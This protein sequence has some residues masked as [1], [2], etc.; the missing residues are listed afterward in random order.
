M[1]EIN[2]YDV[3]VQFSER[4]KQNK[5]TQVIALKNGDFFKNFSDYWL[6]RSKREFSDI[7]TRLTQSTLLNSDEDLCKPLGM[8]YF[9]DWDIKSFL[10]YVMSR[11]KGISLD[12]YMLG[13]MVDAD[14]RLAIYN[15]IQVNLNDIIKKYD[16]MVFP[17]LCAEN[18]IFIEPDSL[19]LQLIDC[20]GFQID[21]YSS[22]MISEMVAED[23][24]AWKNSKYLVKGNSSLYTKELDK[25][26][27]VLLYFFYVFNV[28][29]F[30][31]QSYVNRYDEFISAKL[32]L[33]ELFSL[34]NLQDDNIKHIVWLIFQMDKKKP[35]LYLEEYLLCKLSEEYTLEA[36]RSR[37]GN[38][39]NGSS[40]FCRRLVPKKGK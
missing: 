38:I 1:K 36:F 24:P 29:L 16:N 2:F 39:I 32:S 15:K 21:K 7:E 34:I 33:D 13:S 23:K 30:I 3:E 25:R 4:L 6:A 40:G 37:Y 11:A 26:S 10:G 8:V 14:A 9:E 5:F 28:D 12:D 35:N 18:N 31:T 20:D 19:K 22:G 17:D 27:L